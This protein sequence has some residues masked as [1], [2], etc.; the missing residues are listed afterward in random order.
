MYRGTYVENWM[1]LVY[2]GD[3][4]PSRCHGVPSPMTKSS[5][6]AV[7]LQAPVLA[8]TRSTRAR[9]PANIAPVPQAQLSEVFQ[10]RATSASMGAGS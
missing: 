5:D 2:P 4:S 1:V 6:E 3:T 10:R 9:S 7:T 8:T